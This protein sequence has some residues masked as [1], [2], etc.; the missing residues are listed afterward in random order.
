M[1]NYKSLAL[2]ILNITEYFYSKYGSKFQESFPAE[3]ILFWIYSHNGSNRMFL[4]LSCIMRQTNNLWVG[5]SPTRFDICGNV[6]LRKKSGWMT[7]LRKKS[8]AF[9]EYYCRI[10]VFQLAEILMFPN[11]DL[12]I[13]ELFEQMQ[14]CCCNRK[15]F[16]SV[17]R[18]LKESN[19]ELSE[20][21]V[22]SFLFL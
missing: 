5:K 4:F 15:D 13:S 1:N 8:G 19:S 3:T 2:L 7:L 22:W 16:H 12:C 18:G 20:C 21:F 17:F 9:H 14:R 6:F 10:C 11:K